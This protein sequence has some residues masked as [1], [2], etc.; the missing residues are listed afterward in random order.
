MKPET[1]TQKYIKYTQELHLLADLLYDQIKLA[2]KH[3]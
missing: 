3:L 1:P 2:K